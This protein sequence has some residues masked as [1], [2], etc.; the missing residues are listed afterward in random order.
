[1]TD[2]IASQYD[3][4]VW[5]P[6]VDSSSGDAK[7]QKTAVSEYDKTYGDAPYTAP[8]ST[9]GSSSGSSTYYSLSM[10]YT[11]APDLIPVAAAPPQSSGSAAP[12]ADM[13][14]VQL[15]SLKDAEQACL[16][17]TQSTVSQ[18]QAL[19]SVVGSAISSDSI[20]GQTVDT[21]TKNNGDNKAS[22]LEPA[23]QVTPD[24]L[25]SEGTQFAQ[26]IIPAMQQL[27]AAAGNTIEAMGQFTALLNNAGQMYTD[28]DAQS[29]FPSSPA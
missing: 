14:F 13:F 9:G 15:G 2:P 22:E 17:A 6:T 4:N 20:F 5:Q 16:T 23:V 1:M 3:T 26:S 27:L 11:A 21:V 12:L 28:T 8:P 19:S 29:A 18:Y 25:D 7:D 24:Q 10:A